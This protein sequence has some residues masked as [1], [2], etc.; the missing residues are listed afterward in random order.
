M[1]GGGGNYSPGGGGGN[2]NNGG[3]D[4]DYNFGG[5]P[6]Q[7]NSIDYMRAV[8]FS[9]CYTRYFWMVLILNVEEGAMKSAGLVTSCAHILCTYLLKI[10]VFNVFLSNVPYSHLHVYF[11]FGL[12]H[13]YFTVE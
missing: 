3:H 1:N 5:N 2:P 12:F 4:Y 11:Y 9:I 7:Q 13:H 10:H 8:S 6:G